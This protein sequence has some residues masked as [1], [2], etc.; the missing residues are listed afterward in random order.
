MQ[1]RVDRTL[2]KTPCAI[3]SAQFPDLE[4][5]ELSEGG[6]ARTR[7]E[8]VAVVHR[9]WNVLPSSI[10][11]RTMNCVRWGYRHLDLGLKSASTLVSPR[12]MHGLTNAAFLPTVGMSG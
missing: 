9:S 3:P 12:G 4:G 2:G 1:E 11:R 5:K 7:V 10:S 8:M 6:A